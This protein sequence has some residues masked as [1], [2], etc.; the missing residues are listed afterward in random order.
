MTSLK[1]IKR[2]P[3][4]PLKNVDRMSSFFER[5]L[6]FQFDLVERSVF[7]GSKGGKSVA[8]LNLG[9]VLTSHPLPS[10]EMA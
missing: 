7:K 2:A 4:K 1:F 10:I 6:D 3:W 8:I 9:A 5:Q